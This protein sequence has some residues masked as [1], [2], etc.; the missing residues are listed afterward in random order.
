MLWSPWQRATK[1]GVALAGMGTA[2]LF[3]RV[4]G[5]G[6]YNTPIVVLQNAIQRRP[7]SHPEP[8]EYG[9]ETTQAEG[10]KLHLD[11]AEV[12]PEGDRSVFSTRVFAAMGLPGYWGQ[13]HFNLTVRQARGGS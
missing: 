8:Q 7:L 1:G 11:S 3:G 4:V 5:E 13:A 12:V 6:R 2:C 10:S 9:I